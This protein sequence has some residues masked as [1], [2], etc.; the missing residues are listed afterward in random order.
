MKKQN[1]TAVFL[2]VCLV[3]TMSGMNPSHAHA[4]NQSYYE[5]A[6]LVGYIAIEPQGIGVTQVLLERRN[7]NTLVYRVMANSST[8]VNTSISARIVLQR[9]ES[10]RWVDREIINV[11]QNN[12]IRLDVSDFIDI[13]AH[14]AGSYR[15]RVTFTSVVSGIVTTL[16]PRYST[17]VVM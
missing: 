10:G 4:K 3:I 11:S 15:I 14:G 1:I 17:T 8:G 16:S 6:K 9:L 7:A 13:R 2:A 12:T 5:G